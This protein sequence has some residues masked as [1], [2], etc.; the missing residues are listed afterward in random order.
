LKMWAPNQNIF[1]CDTELH[2]L[3]HFARSAYP[4]E[5][6]GVCVGQRQPE[7]HNVLS[8]HPIQ[9]LSRDKRIAFEM[10]VEELLKVECHARHSGLELVG[11]WHSHPDGPARPSPRDVS[12][13]WNGYSHTI[14]GVSARG[15][16]EVKSWRA[17]E[18]LFQS[19]TLV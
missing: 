6:C 1:F 7:G 2:R 16:I 15:A 5:A 11:F 9:N 13:A 10:D 17:I 19:E 3:G 18:G 14:I 4:H 8:V 12:F